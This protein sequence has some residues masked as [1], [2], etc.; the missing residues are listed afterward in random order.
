MGAMIF[1]W[2]HCKGKNN[3]MLTMLLNFV[4]INLALTVKCSDNDLRF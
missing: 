2:G 1:L 3:I 4:D